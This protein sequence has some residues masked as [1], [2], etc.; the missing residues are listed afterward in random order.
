MDHVVKIWD[1]VELTGTDDTLKVKDSRFFYILDL[2]NDL[3][4]KNF[5]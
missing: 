1:S 2:K 5:R 4:I 3:V